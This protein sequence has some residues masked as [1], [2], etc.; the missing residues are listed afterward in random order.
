VHPS[1]LFRA[2]L[3]ALGLVSATASVSAQADPA[4]EHARKLLRS[5]PLIDGHNDL[6]WTIREFAAAPRDVA[7]YDLRGTVPG[8][9]DLA[10]LKAGMVGAQFWSVYV[11]GEIKDSGYARVQ[12]EQID[13]ARRLVA[14]YPDRLAPAVGADDIQRSFKAGRVASLIGMEGGHA[15]ENSLGALRAYHALG[16]RYMTLTHNVTLDWADAA[17]DTARH[18]GL[19]EFGREVVREMNRLGMLVDL[20]HVSPGTMSDALDVSEA[21]VIFS[22]S[23]ARALVNHKRN[24]PDSILAR[25]PRNGGVVM[26]T[27]V[28]DFV[29]QE[30]ADWVAR[31]DAYVE[32]VKAAT[33]DSAEAQ[34]QA[35]AWTAAHPRPRA[36]L[37]Q[38]AD[39]I[40]HVKQVAG[41]EHV[42]IGSDFDG[43][44]NVVVG[45]EDVSTFPALFAEL[46][47]RGWSDGDLRKLA[48]ENLLRVLRTAEATAARL[49]RQ[50][51]PSTR[52]IE[53]LDGAA[54][55]AS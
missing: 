23:A 21:P 53:Q 27:F 43:I 42:G 5:T 20:S 7:R 50:R 18:G 13:I 36:T 16:A 8:H 26:V 24:V 2:L 51:E 14:R 38:V 39:H 25:L 40:D 32:Q 37:A 1:R 47:R 19:T 45:L 33:P 35:D 48:G 10:R 29:S 54:H 55:H 6:P 22:H 49:Q 44:T 4:L 17:L 41:A 30:V 3:A 15:I 31:F 52:T 34:R 28:P 46:I 11:P 12:L 9:T